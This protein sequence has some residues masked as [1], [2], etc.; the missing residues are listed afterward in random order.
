MK[1]SNSESK[2]SK[3]L[4]NKT[5]LISGGAGS[6][7]S[8]LVKKL[9]KYNV[10]QIRVLDINEHALFKLKHDV[11]DKRLRMLLGSILD[12]E[13]IDMAG[14]SVDIIIHTAAI[15]NIE[16]SEYNPIETIETNIHGTVNMI[17]MAIQKEVKLFINLSTDKAVESST[18]YGATK[19][20][21]ERLTSWA[22]VHNEKSKFATIRFGNVMDSRGNVFEIWNKEIKNKKPLSI[23]HPLVERYF[24]KSEE[25]TD[26]ILKCL[27]LVKTGEIF[28]P[29]M[30]SFKIKDLAKKYSD[31]YKIIGLRQGE[32]IK[33]D[34]IT[35]KEKEIS[36]EKNDMWIINSY[37]NKV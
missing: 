23:T 25:A 36:K 20:L 9:L 1:K 4:K 28:V 27:P 6:I 10:K 31:K 5:I 8:V 26:F 12:K 11:N 32:K 15:K 2:I 18:L 16:I 33:E 3:L 13:R 37:I 7:A 14:N 29:K 19:Q 22:G 24:F 34:L 35:Q 17:K 21:T 30:K